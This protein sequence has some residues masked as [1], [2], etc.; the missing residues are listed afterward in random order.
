MKPTLFL[1]SIAFSLSASQSRNH[2]TEGETRPVYTYFHE[3]F[4]KAHL[5]PPSHLLLPPSITET[6]QSGSPHEPRQDK[7]VLSF[8]S[9]EIERDPRRRGIVYSGSFRNYSEI[10]TYT[11]LLRASAGCA[12]ATAAVIDLSAVQSSQ[13][14][15]IHQ[16]NPSPS[17]SHLIL[18]AHIASLIYYLYSFVLSYVFLF[19]DFPRAG[20]GKDHFLF[21]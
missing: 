7:E 13:R 15:S 4:R 14:A 20:V 9:E 17:P 8:V 19:F 16:S 3:S 1:P 11:I 6:P 21:S 2:P 18:S 12:A 10:P 5:I